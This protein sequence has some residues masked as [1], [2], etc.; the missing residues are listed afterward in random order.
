MLADDEL[1]LTVEGVAV[2]ESSTGGVE[3]AE[4]FIVTPPAA[5]PIPETRPS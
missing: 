5:A 2:S 1:T 4:E 3:S